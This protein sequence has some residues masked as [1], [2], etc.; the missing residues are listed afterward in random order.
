[1]HCQIEQGGGT[2]FPAVRRTSSG[3]G[4]EH[5]GGLSV[6]HVVVTPGSDG[7]DLQEVFTSHAAAEDRAPGPKAGSRRADLR[8]KFDWN[9]VRKY[10]EIGGNWGLRQ[11][12]AANT[13]AAAVL[14]YG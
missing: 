8:R 7:Q 12:S 3:P 9:S 14:V 13:N 11:V 1:M 6:F 4:C 10:A 5:E 2:S